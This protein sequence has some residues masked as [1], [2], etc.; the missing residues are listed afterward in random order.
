MIVVVT[1]GRDFTDA[2][3][4]D[5]ALSH[6]HRETPI[7]LLIHGDCRGAD[8][9]CEAW[10]IENGIET[11]AMPADWKNEGRAAGPLRNGRMLN[12]KPD[13]VVAFPGGRGTANMM[14]Q[15]LSRG[16]ELVEIAE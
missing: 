4:V 9:T 1:G 7:R 13:L 3:L 16:V 2:T 11:K 5:R 15:T 14:N 8:R 6:V 10:A 12:E